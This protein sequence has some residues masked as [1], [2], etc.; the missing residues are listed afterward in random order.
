MGLTVE[1]AVA[2]TGDGAIS[3]RWQ[4]DGVNLNDGGHYS[5]TTTAT[6]IISDADAGDEAGYRCV[7]TAGCGTATSDEAVLTLVAKV[8]PDLDQDCDVDADD[9][10]LFATC[11][12][13]QGII[14][15]GLPLCQMAD[16]DDDN[17]VD[18]PD[19][20]VFQRC[21]SGEKPAADPNC[22]S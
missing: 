10:D 3:Y 12:S 1:F 5:G 16:F 13:G 8:A 4:K 17:D 15:N 22:A 11:A 19:F 21:L 2:A 20:A 7:V 9:F 18:Q 14:H 6:L